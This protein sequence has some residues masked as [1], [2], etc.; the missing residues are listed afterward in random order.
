MI[1][2]FRNTM[3]S[4]TS[5]VDDVLPVARPYIRTADWLAMPSVVAGDQKFVGLFAVFNN[6]SN[7]CS[8]QCASNYTVDWGDGTVENFNA[9]ITAYHIFDYNYAGFVGTETSQGYRQTLITITPQATFNLT[10][11]SLAFKH[12]QAGLPAG[13]DY[14]W[15]DI[16]LAGSYLTTFDC[17]KTVVTSY[18]LREVE[19][20][21]TVA[22]TN[23][24]GM[25]Q[26]CYALEKINLFNTSSA[27][28]VSFMLGNCYLLET[29]PFFD[30]GNVTISQ[31][32]FQNCISLIKVPFFNLE[33][34][35]YCVQMFEGCA[36]IQT[37]PLFNFALMTNC[38]TFVSGCI[39][40]REA[41]AWNMS[42]IQQCYN[43]FI[44]CVKIKSFPLYDLSNALNTANMF[45]GCYSVE[46]FPF[47]NLIKVTNASNMFYGCSKVETYPLYNLA[48]CTNFSGMHNVNT[49]LLTAPF[50]DTIKATTLS[51]MYSSCINLNY[52]P[53]YNLAVCS[54]ISSMFYASGVKKMPPFIFTRATNTNNLFLGSGA[55]IEVPNIDYYYATLSINGFA[56]RSLSKFRAYGYRDTLTF[57]SAKLSRSE[58]Q[59][60]MN[61][62]G[63]PADTTKVV[64]ITNCYGADTPVSKTG[65]GTIAGSTVITQ[66]NTSSLQVGMLVI[67]TGISSS[68]PV[69]MQDSGDTVTL[70]AHGL[71]N[72]TKI[73]FVTIVS[74]TG[75]AVRTTYFVINATANTFQLSLTLGGSVVALTT[76]GTGTIL[77][78]SYIQSINTNV[79]YTI[80]KPASATGSV[81]LANRILDTSL[82]VL[83]G[84]TVTG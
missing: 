28:D 57:T 10:K 14:G 26:N 7:F 56:V 68:V 21:G 79:S 65:C 67:G 6:D 38:H 46:S 30:F 11:V 12:N 42:L 47:F 8:F 5:G 60:I 18:L 35:W 52:C 49:R 45:Q 48:N 2:S 72:G 77:Y 41:P 63:V 74:T 33:K 83:H 80:D 76:D 73:A 64:Q 23:C 20:I 17:G 81:T 22:F 54:D 40:L 70:N 37:L 36:R 82:P 61:N 43:M 34:V 59:I 4:G 27:T 16:K 25:F 75:I 24:G 39:N 69:T 31:G 1:G 51:S 19:V 58:L 32:T 55:L 71:A 44:N 15:L 84:F 29:C 62:C 53:T 3:A 78:A 66:S 9:N 13:I 50:Y